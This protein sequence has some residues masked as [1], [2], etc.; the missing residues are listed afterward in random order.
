M[1]LAAGHLGGQGG[2]VWS[3]E[4]PEARQPGVR[5]AQC[6]VV[7]RVEP[8]GALGAHRG[9][10]VLPQHPQV[11]GDGRLGDAELLPDDRRH[12][13]GALLAV[14]EQFEDPSPYRVTEDVERVHR[15]I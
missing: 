11:L 9:E 2:Q 4:P 5:L 7:H 1:P 12:R 6:G 15:D 10:A 13:A 14:G 8:A 3:P